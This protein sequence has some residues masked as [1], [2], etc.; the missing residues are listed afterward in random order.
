L[1]KAGYKKSN[2]RNLKAMKLIAF[3]TL[4]YFAGQRPAKAEPHCLAEMTSF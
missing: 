2:N 3:F 4:G 1:E